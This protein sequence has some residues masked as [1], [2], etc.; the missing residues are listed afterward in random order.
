MYQLDETTSDP[1]VQLI[2]VSPVV[3]ILGATEAE[4]VFRMIAAHLADKTGMS[5]EHILRLLVKREQDS[6]TAITPFVAIPH[7]IV[8]GQQIF[9]LFI[10]RCQHGIRFSHTHQH[11]KAMF[12]LLG[13]KDERDRHLKT[14][15]AIAQIVQADDFEKKWQLASNEQQLRD[16]LILLS[17][18]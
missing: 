12:A 4:E 10:A 7:I 1:F 11:V 8:D 15:A 18:R 2:R 5:Q 14:L 17:K 13:T 16:M 3:D 9:H 6:S